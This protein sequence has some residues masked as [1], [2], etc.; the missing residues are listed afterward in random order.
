M[1]ALASFA[2]LSA[3]AIALP[4][5]ARAEDPIQLYV[6]FAKENRIAANIKNECK[7]VDQLRDFIVAGSGGRVT[8]ASGEPNTKKGSVLVV[9]I[10]DSVSQGN[11]FVG[12]RK[13]T[14]IEGR[15]YQGGAQSADFEAS[16]N[17]MGGAFAGYKGSCAVLGRTVK[18]LAADVNRWLESP[19][20]GAALGDS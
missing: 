7:L 10:T 13:Y 5:L 20:Q 17:S 1:R 18:A 3:F 19:T 6:S 14:A 11:A 12:H 9:E 4:Q 2:L 8:A 15:L 16:R